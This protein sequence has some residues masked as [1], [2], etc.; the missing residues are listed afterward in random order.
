[1][2]MND[3]CSQMK[4]L[5]RCTCVRAGQPPR[6]QPCQQSQGLP[7]RAETSLIHSELG[8]GAYVEQGSEDAGDSAG[9]FRVCP[10]VEPLEPREHA[11]LLARFGSGSRHFRS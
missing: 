6:G 8:G 3:K 4:S 5:L 2:F 1:M 11:L 9:C 10:V 7:R